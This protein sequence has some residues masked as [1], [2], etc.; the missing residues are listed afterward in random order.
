MRI[1]GQ[2]YEVISSE[3]FLAVLRNIGI[4]LT[5]EEEMCLLQVLQKQQLNNMISMDELTEIMQSVNEELEELEK[6]GQ[7][8]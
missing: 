2:V 6:Q 7:F 4:D 5:E 1:K 3:R 8:G